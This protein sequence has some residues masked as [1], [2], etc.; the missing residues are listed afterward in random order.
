M[1]NWCSER[2]TAPALEILAREK[3]PAAQ[4]LKPQEVLEDPQVQAMGFLSP[5]DYPGLR[6]PAPIA[7]VPVRLS[8]SPGEVGFRAPRLGEHT[9]EIMAELGFDGTSI[10][11]LHRTGVI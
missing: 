8:D 11:E 7:K 2:T 10:A 5:L 3:I 1:Q 6:R 4:V 9:D